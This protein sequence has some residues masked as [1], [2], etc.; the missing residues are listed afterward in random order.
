[1]VGYVQMRPDGK[2]EKHITVLEA[3]TA[4]AVQWLRTEMANKDIYKRVLQR[5]AA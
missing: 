2:R 5:A 3:C 1:L 4:K